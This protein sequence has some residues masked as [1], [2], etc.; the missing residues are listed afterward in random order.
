MK[1]SEVRAAFL[2]YFE[3]KGHAIVQSSSLVPGNDP[4]LLF[5]NAGMVQFKDVFLGDDIR[6]YTRATTSQ[7]CVRAGGKH[8]DLENVGFTARHHTFFE[9]LGNFSFGDYFKQGAIEYAWDF[10]VNVMGL[11]SKR[12]LVSVYKDDDEAYG[13]W[14]D[15][16]GVSPDRIVR[17]GEK[18]NFWSMGDTG[19]CGPCSEIIYDQGPGVG[20]GKP[21]C[22]VECGCDRFLEIWNLVFMQFNRDVSGKL[23]PLPKPNIDTGMGLERITAILQGVQS[24]YDTD[25]FKPLIS[26]IARVSGKT[27][28][29]SEEID[30]SIRVIADHARAC[31]FLIGDG[32]LP[33]NEG[34]GYVLRRIMR[35][36]SRYGKQLGMNDPF[37]H[38]VAMQVV[39]EMGDIYPDLENRKEF[40]AKV[41][42]NE[43][44]RFLKT[45]DRG[46]GLLSEVKTELKEKGN[47]MIPGDVVFM[48]YDTFGFP[49][50]LTEGEAWK[51]GFGIDKQ[52]FETLMEKQRKM[53]QASTSFGARETA[54]GSARVIRKK[55]KF[56]GYKTLET[57]S[58]ILAIQGEDQNGLVSDLKELN[59]GQTG[60]LFTDSTSFYGESGGQIGDTGKIE[61]EGLDA[62]VLDTTKTSLDVVVHNVKVNKGVLKK[63]QKIDLK[64]DKARRAAIMR[65]HSATH[66]LQKALRDVL[67]GHVHQSGSLVTDARLRFDFTHFAALG[68]D[69]IDRIEDIVNQYVLTDLPVTIKVMSKEEALEMGAM[70]LFNEKYGD[71]VRVVSMGDV[72]TEL[73][74][75]THCKSTGEIGLVKIVSEGS[76]SA[77]LRR[78]EAVAGIE[79]LKH[80]R[81][82]NNIVIQTAEKVKASPGEII[83]RV[84]AM[85]TR[86]KEQEQ[87]IKELNLKIATGSVGAS[88]EQEFMADGFSVVIKKVDAE[89]VG[90]LRDIGDR[91]KERVG[92]GVV[93][94][95]S[96]MKGK[97]TFVI[98]VTKGLEERVDAGKIMREIC[99]AVGGRGGGKGAFAQGGTDDMS[100]LTKAL[101][102][103]NEEIRRIQA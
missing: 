75:G 30:A 95:T 56:L 80:L 31:A 82:L 71:Q 44:E 35:R 89:D 52:G 103:F 16:I 22:N 4:T 28:G 84:S 1:G 67:G 93:F 24:N 42:S 85:H 13:L 98:M 81:L 61:A 100:S 76:I 92:K 9:M 48:L 27:Y 25:L 23:T 88:D 37:L 74:G 55:T 29:K 6:P 38:D 15:K 17:L 99:N 96:S 7:K 58:K 21:T 39:K 40:I 66:L 68:V 3:S 70:A 51:D 12:L 32:I 63:G 43:E 97:N 57:T 19:P 102:I 18:D 54:K 64:V 50:D 41:I 14:K 11:D 53:A 59:P 62:D 86:I 26:Y 65:H 79:S 2:K 20:C 46:L 78:I 73:C 69:E 87:K 34:R 90:Q 45:L 91:I 60:M 10:L 101:E 33:S 36:A 49:I 5:T 72:S 83:D 77:G 94:L 47:T 8:N